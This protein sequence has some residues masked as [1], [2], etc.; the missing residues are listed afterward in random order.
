MAAMSA[1]IEFSSDFDD[2]AQLAALYRAAELG[3]RS[4][5]E[6]V[7]AFRNSRYKVFATDHGRLVGAGRAFGDEV[8]CAV[9]CDLAVRPEMQGCGLGG[10]ML[11][12]LKLQARHHTRIILYAKPGKET[13]YLKRGFSRMKT[14]MLMSFL[15]SA[16]TN[17]Q[18]GLIE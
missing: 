7:K 9:I 3:R 4:P 13:F 12:S 2:N 15:V 6:I 17:R 10:R 16:E 14:A 11:E 5:E 1:E 8:D 18:R